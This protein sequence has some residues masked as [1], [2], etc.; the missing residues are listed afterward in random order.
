ME[1]NL[2]NINIDSIFSMSVLILLYFDVVLK[3]LKK[4]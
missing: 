3:N 2:I 1:I 4:K